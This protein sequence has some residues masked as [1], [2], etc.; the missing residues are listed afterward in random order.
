MGGLLES[1]SSKEREATGHRT[2]WNH[3]LELCVEWRGLSGMGAGTVGEAD[4]RATKD[5]SCH[6]LI[7]RIAPPMCCFDPGRAL[8]R[9]R[10]SGERKEKK[11]EERICSPDI[12]AGWRERDKASGRFNGQ[13]TLECPRKTENDQTGAA[14]VWRVDAVWACPVASRVLRARFAVRLSS[15]ACECQKKGKRLPGN[16]KLVLPRLPAP[17]V[18]SIFRLVTAGVSNVSMH[19]RTDEQTA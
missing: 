16:K 7:G 1:T 6:Q 4:K 14:G 17:L 13:K 10:I 12:P 9:P 11:G 18:G 15:V 8:H 5:N 19:V 2:R 3:S